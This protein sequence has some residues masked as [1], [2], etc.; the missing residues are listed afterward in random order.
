MKTTGL[1]LSAGHLQVIGTVAAV[2]L[3]VACSNDLTTDTALQGGVLRFEVAEASDW[4]SRPQ[5]R[6][7]RN[8]TEIS[9]ITTESESTGVLTLQGK[10]PADTLFLHASVADGI[11][12]PHLNVKPTDRRRV[13]LPSK[14]RLFTIR[15]VYWLRFIRGLG[16]RIPA[17]R[18]ICTMS[19]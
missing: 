12:E 15:S 4:H 10:K 5:S 14:R 3:F 11:A 18:I 2:L 13:L 17:Y 9:E 6:A 8:T 7:V 1:L 16:A 19:R